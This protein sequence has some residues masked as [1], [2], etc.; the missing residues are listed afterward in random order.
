MGARAAL[1]GTMM[2]VGIDTSV[3]LKEAITA[4]CVRWQP[5]WITYV[6]KNWPI[7]VPASKAGFSS[8]ETQLSHPLRL[9]FASV[10]N[11]QADLRAALREG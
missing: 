9:E 3:E 6:C 5:Q 4:P 1:E 8:I 10:T 2:D 7:I 11:A